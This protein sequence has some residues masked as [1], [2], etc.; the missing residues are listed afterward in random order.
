MDFL[1]DAVMA[2]LA[3]RNVALDYACEVALVS[4]TGT[5]LISDFEG[6]AYTIRIVPGPLQVIQVRHGHAYQDETRRCPNCE[7]TDAELVEKLNAR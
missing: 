6:G 1:H 2:R 5:V 7:A 3:K 4:G